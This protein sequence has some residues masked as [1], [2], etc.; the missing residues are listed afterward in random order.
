MGIYGFFDPQESLENTINTMGTLLGV[1]GTPNCPLSLSVLSVYTWSCSFVVQSI[2][3]ASQE[4]YLLLYSPPFL[5]PLV[6]GYFPRCLTTWP[7]L[8]SQ[9]RYTWPDNLHDAG[10]DGF[11]FV[12]NLFKHLPLHNITDTVG[13]GVSVMLKITCLWKIRSISPHPRNLICP[14]EK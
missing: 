8:P 14:L 7:F 12:K 6:H 3:F 5:L 9:V 2:S 10:L 4:S 11:G 1:H 13:T